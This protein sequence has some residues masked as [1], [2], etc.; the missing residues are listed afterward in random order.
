M[1]D[2][3]M[4]NDAVRTTSD[5]RSGDGDTPEFWRQLEQCRAAVDRA[6]RLARA[7]AGQMIAYADNKT[8]RHLLLL[9]NKYVIAS[10]ERS[11][12]Y[13]DE[14]IRFHKGQGCF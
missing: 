6:D 14:V 3:V 5:V 12:K 8:E 10:T 1:L 7:Q 13:V 9:Y 2:S 11:R 4:C